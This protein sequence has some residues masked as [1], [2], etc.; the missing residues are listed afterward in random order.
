M[1]VTLVKKNIMLCILSSIMLPA[2]AQ[3]KII[4]KD[5]ETIQG[6]NVDISDKYVF[7][8]T[9][10]KE[11]APFV[12]LE[13]NN[14]L[15]V[16]K[17]N[18]SVVNLYEDAQS[19]VETESSASQNTSKES[20][21]PVILKL[22]SLNED[23]QSVNKRLVDCINAD[24]VFKPKSEN[25]LEKTANRACMIMGMKENSV[26]TDGDISMEIIS[27]VLWKEDK[28]KDAEFKTKVSPNLTMINPA[29]MVRIRNQSDRTL[30]ID[31]GNSFYI[32]MGQSVCYY[33]P[34]ST[35]TSSSS[36]AGAGVNL[37]SVAGALGVG[38]VV[39]QLAR[40]VTVGGGNTN[41]TSNTTYAKRVISVPPHA[42]VDLD[43]QY[44][45][46]NENSQIC[47]GFKYF[48]GGTS[49]WLY[50]Q[51]SFYNK[52]EHGPLM[53]GTHL[54]YLEES[55][56]INLSVVIA[57]SFSEDCTDKRMLSANMY[58][59]D[60]IGHRK[61]DNLESLRYR[62]VGDGQKNANVNNGCQRILFDAYVADSY[63]VEFPRK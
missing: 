51:L 37:G 55:S 46:G 18:G 4:T 48:S 5:G 19:A 50:P 59:K 11:N 58:L 12:R 10:N 52:S 24:I 3:D 63:E 14:V 17:Q 53:V 38:G 39:G 43:A 32:R 49:Y 60:I 45:F 31:L 15:M 2:M 56:P 16:K 1:M 13:K 36:S 23:A 41:G 54:T 22:E 26:L 8:N 44:A 7:Y 6:W 34:S 57:Y 33:I 21:G 30:Y 27:G 20:S 25:D 9:E 62:M 40:G 61:S 29:I 35:T 28:Q 42:N 47:K